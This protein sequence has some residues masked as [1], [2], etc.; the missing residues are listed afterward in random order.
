MAGVAE[1]LAS[2]TSGG[3]LS[4]SQ[5]MAMSDDPEDAKRPPSK[6]GAKLFKMQI[7]SA[8][9]LTTGVT[10]SIFGAT[11]DTESTGGTVASTLGYGALGL[12]AGGIGN[13]IH[14]SRMVSKLT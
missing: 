2:G 5:F 9:A 13:A 14:T 1:S 3:G 10:G 7:L 8:A 6:V 12:T 11:R 4:M